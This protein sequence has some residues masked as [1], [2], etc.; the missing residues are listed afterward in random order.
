MI[1]MLSYCPCVPSTHPLPP[2][3]HSLQIRRP[4]NYDINTA[5]MLG[6][7][8]SDPTMD[9]G[10]LDMCRAV[11]EDSPSK[12]FIG[13]LQCDWS[14]EEVKGLLAPYGALK[15]FNLVM[16]KVTGKSKVGGWC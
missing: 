5:M 3:P 9:T 16:D 4:S 2:A 13:G 11:V 10:G 15:S 7:V 8:T 12:L 6:P 14:E 1:T